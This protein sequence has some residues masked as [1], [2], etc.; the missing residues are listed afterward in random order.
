MLSTA[1]LLPLLL[2]DPPAADAWRILRP[3]A[4]RSTAGTTLELREDGSV[5]ASGPDAASDVYELEAVVEADGLVALRLEAIPDPALPGGGSSRSANANLCVSEIEVFAAATKSRKKAVP[6]RFRA[7]HQTRGDRGTGRRLIDGN[8]SSF[9]V[10]HDSAGAPAVVVLV[11]EAPFGFAQGTALTVR[12]RQESRW[13]NHGLGRFR[14]AVTEDPAAAEAYAPQLDPLALRADAATWSGIQL[15]IKRQH[16]DGT[17]FDWL[18]PQHPAGMTALCAYALFKAGMPREHATLQLALAYLDTHPAEYT[19]DAALRILLYTSLDPERW[20]ERIEQAA[21]VLLY[22]PDNYFTYLYAGGKGGGGDLSNHQFAVVA[23]HAL[24]EHGFALDRK[25]WERLAGRILA[26]QKEDGSFGYSP[27]G[28]ATP[29]MSLAGLAVASACRNAYERNGWAKKDQEV[30]SHAVERAAAWCGSHWLLD[31]PRDRGPLDRWFTYGCYGMERAAALAGLERIGAHDWYAEVATELCDLQHGD[32]SWSNPWGEHELNT[33]FALLTLARAT[34]ATGLPSIAARFAPRWS[35]AGSGADLAITAVGAPELQVYLA[36]VGK[37]AV[38]DFAWEGE[39]RP[40]ILSV[41]WLL[42]GAPAGEP[43]AAERD[44]AAAARG[45]AMPRFAQRIALPGNGDFE[46]RAI[47]SVIPPGGAAED[48]E[49][50][51]SPPLKIEVR[52]LVD[53]A[54][55]EAMERMRREAWVFPPEFRV[56]AASS[57]H[58]GDRTGPKLAFDRGESTRWA[59]AADDAEP[60][61]RAEWK[62]AVPVGAVR[63]LPALHSGRLADGSGFDVPR[64]VL[65]ILNGKD[66]RLLDFGPAEMLAGATVRFERKL[67]LRR[68]EVR[69]LERD[70]GAEHPGLAGWREIQF[71]AP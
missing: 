5:A 9:W 20:R 71:L 57:T 51:P 19:Y 47:A 53:A 4:L 17:W 24:D 60:W 11:A 46:L 34:A 23:L 69:I 39:D 62:S 29:T 65:L 2:Q 13:Q 8:R 14:L 59:C 49:E 50:L 70:P 56:L 25:L 30:L 33:A 42:D 44:P 36:G 45:L 16:P 43:V 10:V 12:I 27:D 18:E 32:G 1:I 37:R 55:R 52:G 21:E 3:D 26:A 41:Q 64:K 48:A 54:L 35:S 66:E 61:I 67:N 38:A 31:Q 22:L 15:L 40:R 7:V 63:L 68:V 6:V 28:E 58:D